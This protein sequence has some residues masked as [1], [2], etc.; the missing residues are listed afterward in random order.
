[1]A[2]VA[3]LSITRP[4]GCVGAAI[5][6]IYWPVAYWQGPLATAVCGQCIMAVFGAFAALVA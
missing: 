6:G 2:I 4:A 5:R 1:M 3:P